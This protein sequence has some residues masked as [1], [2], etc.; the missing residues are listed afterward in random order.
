MTR[1]RARIAELTVEAE[2]FTAAAR[3]EL[4]RL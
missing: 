2:T 3:R 4:T 1:L